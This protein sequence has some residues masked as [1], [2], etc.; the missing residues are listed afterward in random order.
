MGSANVSNRNSNEWLHVGKAWRYN[1]RQPYLTALE[2]ID[3]M[4]PH[5]LAQG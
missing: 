2:V 5:G 3:P 4:L 1:K